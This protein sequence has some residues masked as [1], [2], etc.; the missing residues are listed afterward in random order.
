MKGLNGGWSRLALS[1]AVAE[2]ID[3]CEKTK[4]DVFP[5][6]AHDDLRGGADRRLEAGAR[7]V[8]VVCCR[9]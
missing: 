8:L 3:A 4:L 9:S 2:A 5:F 6:R 1:G 7:R